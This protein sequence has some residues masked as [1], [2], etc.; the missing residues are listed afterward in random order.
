[1]ATRAKNM[2][3]LSCLLLG[4]PVDAAEIPLNLRGKSLLLNWSRTMTYKLLAG[5][6]AGQELINTSSLAVRLYVSAKGRVFSAF[7]DADASIVNDVQGVGANALHWRYE[8]GA[9]VADQAF[10]KG[11]RRIV[12]S[13]ADGFKTCSL[14]LIFGKRNGT[15]PLTAIGKS[16]NDVPVE[17]ANI[18][19]LSATCSIQDGN[20]FDSGNRSAIPYSLNAEPLDT[21]I[22]CPVGRRV[23]QV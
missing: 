2:L 6:K 18:K 8:G 12:A 5:P 19:L 16:R 10:L 13:S 14:N 3:L 15:D 7:Q 23:H 20:I 11:A 17:L 9:L 1:M 22:G 21:G 4:A